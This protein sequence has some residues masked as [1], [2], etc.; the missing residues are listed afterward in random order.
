MR[1]KGTFHH[2]QFIVLLL[3]TT[4]LVSY[5]FAGDGPEKQHSS[6][7]PFLE[8]PPELQE[9]LRSA[10]GDE[11]FEAL[12]KSKR[13]PTEA[14]QQKIDNCMRTFVP[15]GP[16]IPGDEPYH[17]GKYAES[18]RNE[19]RRMFR[20]WREGTDPGPDKFIVANP[21]NLS[22]FESISPFRS[23][24]G[25]DYSGWNTDEVKETNRHMKH[26]ITQREQIK[27]ATI[28]APFDGTI[29]QIY[30]DSEARGRQVWLEPKGGSLW[31]FLFH[32]VD[33]LR[34]FKIGSK[35]KAGELMGYGVVSEARNF[36]I[37][38]KKFFGFRGPNI[39]D[40]PFYHMSDEVLAE[41]ERYG[42]TKENMVISKEYRDANPCI[43]GPGS[44]SD[45][46]VF[47]K[48]NE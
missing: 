27:S 19:G 21:I 45:E 7:N 8:G 34:Q 9:S 6:V 10:L 37:G 26:Y 12:A 30:S 16:S 31:R 47:L 17:G 48:H 3:L 43:F 29:T 13:A 4:F 44:G 35:V 38:V 36:D 18:E 2:F 40:T 24:M 25:H 23:C 28:F 20:L 42:I 11:A 41:Y 39:Y 1:K 5:A 33:L 46:I 15:E 32:H 22:E 14:E